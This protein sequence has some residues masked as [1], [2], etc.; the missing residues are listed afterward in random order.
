MFAFL[1]KNLKSLLIRL[2]LVFLDAHPGM[3]KYGGQRGRIQQRQQF[4]TFPRVFPSQPHLHGTLYLRKILHHLHQSL[5]PLRVRQ[6]SGP[7]SPSGNHRERTSHVN[8]HLLVSPSFQH[9][10][11]NIQLHRLPA[12]Y[13]W[14]Q[15]L[16]AIQLRIAILHIPRTK[17]ILLLHPNKRRVVSI[18]SPE[19]LCMHIPVRP[20]GNSL[21][22]SKMYLILFHILTLINFTIITHSNIEPTTLNISESTYPFQIFISPTLF[23]FYILRFKNHYNSVNTGRD[24]PPNVTIP[25]NLRKKQT[26]S[27]LFPVQLSRI[28]TN[29][30]LKLNFTL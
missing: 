21:Y 17:R 6:Q 24:Y 30:A 16:H 25:A 29:Y 3:K 20:I 7:L 22:R 8:I 12:Q 18:H 4:Q 27:P 19:K 9:L 13:L 2:S 26:I 15:Q 1:V 23:K 10:Q 28:F 5:H 14:N 11:A